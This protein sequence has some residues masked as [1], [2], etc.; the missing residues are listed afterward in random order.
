MTLVYFNLF[1]LACGYGLLV[2]IAFRNVNCVFKPEICNKCEAWQECVECETCDDG[3][4]CTP[5]CKLDVH[6]DGDEYCDFQEGGEGN[7]IKGC[8]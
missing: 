1:H 2:F 3:W 7:C 5:D 6:C 4:M 8:R